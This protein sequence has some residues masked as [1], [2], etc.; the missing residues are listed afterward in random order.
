VI[1][2]C[3]VLVPTPVAPCR[4]KGN[5][6]LD[7]FCGYGGNIIQFA[8]EQRDALVI[9]CDIVPDHIEM[10]KCVRR[11][12]VVSSDGFETRPCCFRRHNAR[13]YGVEDRIEFVC[14]DAY[15]VLASLQDRG[16]VVDAVFLSPPWG[17]PRYI[18]AEVIARHPLPIHCHRHRVA[19]VGT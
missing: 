11:M 2:L 16:A 7:C 5:V 17:G 15:D 12:G 4:L 19:T 14:G 13:I 8:L 1:L 9:G 6:I 18:Q 3:L 10:A